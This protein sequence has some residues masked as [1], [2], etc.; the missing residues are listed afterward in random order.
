MPDSPRPIPKSRSC[1][2]SRTVCLRTTPIASASPH[3]PAPSSVSV[4]RA[5]T[6]ET[7]WAIRRLIEAA[8][9]DAAGRPRVRRHALGRTAAARSRR[10]PG[11]VDPRRARP[12]RRYR[13]VPSCVTCALRWSRA[14]AP[15]PSYRARRAR[16]ARDRAARAQPPGGRRAPGRV[17]GEDPR[18]DGRQS[19]VRPRAGS[20]ARGRRCPPA[21]ARR[22]ERHRGRRRDPGPADDPVAAIC[23]RRPLAQRR[24]NGRRA[25]FRHR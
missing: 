24:A 23:A 11:R 22:V 3:V 6:E 17:A 16:P 19:A 12:A 2:R 13:L 18:V 1:R 20:H 14:D 5:R 9:R 7:F 10:A 21:D 15:R 25:R 8:A 4:S